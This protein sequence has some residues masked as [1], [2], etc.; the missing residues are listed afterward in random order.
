MKIINVFN[1]KRIVFS[2]LSMV[3]L[4]LSGCMKPIDDIQYYEYIPAFVEIDFSYGIKLNT[5]IGS[6]VSGELQKNTDLWDGDA[7]LA[8]FTV[9]YDQQESTEYIVAYDIGYVIVETG[10]AVG[11]TEEDSNFDDNDFPIENMGVFPPLFEN[12]LFLGF[13]HKAPG[14]QKFN[15]LMTFDRDVKSGTQVLKIR[16]KKMGE[17]KENEKNFLYPYAFNLRSFFNNSDEKNP[18][19]FSIQYKTGVDK[20]GNDEFKT[21]IDNNGDSIFKLVIE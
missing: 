2:F 8:F 19:R 5:P 13:G 3:I 11:I 12:I 7:I 14:D 16:A 10:I 20:D 21:Y 1:M 17:G 4:W 15:Y 6:I 9:N 18:L